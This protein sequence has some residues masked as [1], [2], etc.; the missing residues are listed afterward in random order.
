MKHVFMFLAS[1]HFRFIQFAYTQS[2]N[3]C[4]DQR[5]NFFWKR[6]HVDMKIQSSQ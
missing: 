3:N 2:V 1:F 6:T 5:N 4:D